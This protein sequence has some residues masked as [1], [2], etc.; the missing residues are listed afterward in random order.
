MNK[1]IYFDMDGT[2]AK[3]FDVPNWLEKLRSED[4]TPY[5]EAEPKVNLILLAEILNRAK[6]LGYKVGVISWLSM[7]GSYRYNAKVRKA[8][9]EWL[10]QIPFEFDEI[11]IVRYGTPKHKLP[12]VKNGLLIDDNLQVC[13]EWEKVGGSIL[14]AECDTWIHKL[15]VMI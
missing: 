11:H 8:K 2:I 9:K 15:N 4:P 13:H 7:D 6:A 1:A 5:I 3:L 12:H 10:K 14:C